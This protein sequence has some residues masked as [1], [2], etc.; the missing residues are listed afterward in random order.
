MTAKTLLFL[1][2]LAI[3]CTSLMGQSELILRH[4][5]KQKKTKKIDLDRE[6]QIRTVDTVYFAKVIA[7]TD[8]TIL[9]PTRKRTGKD[10]VYISTHTYRKYSKS[11]FLQI[12]EASDTT[13]ENR[14]I[15]PL[16]RSDTTEIRFADIKMLKTGWFKSTK[17]LEPFGWVLVGSAL[18][19]VWLPVAA[20]DEGVQGVQEWAA[21]EGVLLGI[22]LPP[23]FIGSRN[24]RYDLNKRWILT[25]Q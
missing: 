3:Q 20:I 14:T 11:T 6:F 5:R 1:A 7:F 17:W 10:T 12:G 16:Y 8:S 23:I 9:I 4:K 21:F 22:A 13:I 2:L 15:I 18:G 24:M 25:T 19:V